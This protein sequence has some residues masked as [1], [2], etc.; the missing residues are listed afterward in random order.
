MMNMKRVGYPRTLSIVLCIAMLLALAVG[1]ATATPTQG[2]T[3]TAAPTN[4]VIDPVGKYDPPIDAT[5][6]GFAEFT[7]IAKGLGEELEDNRWIQTIRE[8]LGINCSYLWVAANDEQYGTKFNLALASGEIPDITRVS[9]TNMVKMVEAGLVQDISGTLKYLNPIGKKIFEDAGDTPFM[10]GTVNGVLY[11]LPFVNDFREDSHFL[12]LRTDWLTKLDLQPPKTMDELITIIKAFA[13]NDPDGNNVKDT[14]GLGLKNE[15]ISW[16]GAT[17][18]GFFEGYHAHPNIWVEKN[19]ML[20]WGSIQP[21]IKTALAK[22][23]ELYNGGYIDPEFAV[24]DNDKVWEEVSAGK[25]GAWY[26]QHWAGLMLSASR[27]NNPDA[28]WQPYPIVSADDKKAIVGCVN[29]TQEFWVVRKGYEHPEALIKM[30]NKYYEKNYDP[31]LH[32]FDRLGIV[33]K[34]DGSGSDT[35]TFSEA[36]KLSPVLTYK[37]SLNAEY[38]LQLREPL[39]TGDSSKLWGEALTV[40][41]Q[42]VAGAKGD[43]TNYGWQFVYGPTSTWYIVNENYN[44]NNVWMLD[45]FYGTPTPTMLTKK[46]TLDT[47]QEEVFTKIIMG[48]EPLTAFDQFV[49]DW[50]SLGGDDMTKEVNDWKAAQK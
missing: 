36:W 32:E 6:I 39:K 16:G 22:L 14:R 7:E 28:D 27:S 45:G 17:L 30:L 38:D 3:P 18:K 40:F 49:A 34:T 4:E 47:M 9:L 19:G 44:V 23:N 48:Q 25:I 33:K 42:V 1:C 24:K 20:E 43:L 50:K 15:L 35:F 31:E 41:N 13:D 2:S 11:G 26:G 8:E 5:L 37:A 12:F 10:Q 46:S 21:E 29:P